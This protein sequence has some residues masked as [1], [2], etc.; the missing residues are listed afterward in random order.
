LKLLSHGGGRGLSPSLPRGVPHPLLEALGRVPFRH[1]VR[2]RID[3]PAANPGVAALLSLIIP[4][5][6]QIYKGQILNGLVWL[7][8]VYTGYALALVGSVLT[9]GI[10]LIA[11]L[12][13]LIFL[14]LCCIFGAATGDPTKAQSSLP[15]GIVLFGVLFIAGII[16]STI[17]IPKFAHTKARTYIASMKEDLRNLV[18]AEE[19]Y[20]GHSVKYSAA[21]TCMPQ[22]GTVV[23]CAATGNKLSGPTLSGTGAGWSATMTNVN[24]PGIICAIFVNQ[25]AVEPATVEGAPTCG[26]YR[27]HPV[28]QSSLGA[29]RRTITINGH[30]AWVDPASGLKVWLDSVNTYETWVVE[31]ERWDGLSGIFLAYGPGRAVTT[32]SWAIR[33]FPPAPWKLDTTMLLVKLG[34]RQY[35]LPRYGN[36]NG[37]PVSEEL[38]RAVA[39][40]STW[41]INIPVQG[42]HWVDVESVKLPSAQAM[43]P[44]HAAAAILALSQKRP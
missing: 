24:I 21:V 39:A 36:S 41:Q 13:P 43:A 11:L 8:V 31:L 4:G 35:S 22:S 23:W 14:H 30:E 7:F 1:G 29:A 9:F 10:S 19:D 38:V 6:G 20:F 40:A 2:D 3:P 28:A 42:G 44:Q 17:A 27:P 33:V 12:P 15:G 16:L 32:S 26:E 5:A 37:Y 18:T 34:T 25:A